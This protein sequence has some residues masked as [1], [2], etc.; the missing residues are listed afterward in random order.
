MQTEFLLQLQT[1]LLVNVAVD[2]EEY[3]TL[4]E[5]N[6]LKH[7][8]LNDC[9]DNEIMSYTKMHQLQQQKGLRYG[10][11][12]TNIYNSFVGQCVKRAGT[13]P[14]HAGKSPGKP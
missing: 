14:L 9:L 3:L 8:V 12:R 5:I 11:R 13:S 10:V 4:W 2:M 6:L 1:I 7:D